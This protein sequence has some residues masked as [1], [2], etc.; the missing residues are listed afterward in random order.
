MTGASWP[1]PIEGFIFDLDGTLYRGDTPILGA[2]QAVR[3]LQENGIPTVF[4]TNNSTRSRRDVADK[5]AGLGY[6]TDEDRIVNSSF[7]TRRYLAQTF[8]AGEQVFVIGSNALR[9]EVIRAGFTVTDAEAPIVVVGLDVEL[10]YARLRTAVH[11]IRGGAA[12][13]LTNPDRV[14]PH[15]DGLDPGAGS[16]AA[17]ITAAT[18]GFARPVVIGKPEPM[19]FRMALE[20]LGS[21]R[22]HTVAVGDQLLTD[23]AGARRAGVFAVLVES[24]VPLQ[25]TQ[26]VVPDMVLPS[27]AALT[28]SLASCAHRE[29]SLS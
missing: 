25:R 9:E 16:V 22:G 6:E 13:V 17:A 3:S 18:D 2:L 21:R 1:D 10:T 8:G 26:G 5:L 7:A 24:G 19:M 12:F 28:A 4:V 23:V 14:I 15:G 20:I 29:S 11:S 27:V